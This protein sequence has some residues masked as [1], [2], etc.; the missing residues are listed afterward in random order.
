MGHGEIEA[1]PA[2]KNK[3]DEIQ[4][5]V[6]DVYVGVFF[7]GTNNNMLQ[8]MIGQKFRRDKIFKSRADALKKLG[9]KNANEVIAKPRS[10]WE[11]KHKDVF[12]KSDLDKLYGG[13]S[14]N[15]NDLEKEIVAENTDYS[16]SSVQANNE[17]NPINFGLG[18]QFKKKMNE[19][20][21]PKGN[22]K[23]S[24]NYLPDK[25]VW[26]AF[27]QSS[28]YTNPCILWSIYSTGEEQ[29]QQDSNHKIYHHRIYVEGSGSD[30]TV[31][32]AANVDGAVDD[33]IGLGFGV[34]YTG[35]S[36]KCRKMATQINNIYGMYHKPD[37]KEIRF[38]FD[39]FGFSRGATTARLFT[40]IVNPNNENNISNNDF[41]L[42]TGKAKTF[43]PLH[44][45]DSSSL[46]TKKEVRLLGIFDTVA[47]IG[48]LRDPFNTAVA[49]AIKIKD[50]NVEFTKYG[51]SQ[52]HDRNV[53]D[54]GL[55]ATTN[56]KDVLHICALD[57][58]RINFSLT[59][60]ESSVNSGNGTEIFLPGCHTDIGG[61]AGL[62]LDDF[63]VI[64]KETSNIG[65]IAG[66]LMQ[67]VTE[68][69]NLASDVKKTL[70]GAKNVGNGVKSIV[71]GYLKVNSGDLIGIQN[72]L[73]GVCTTYNGTRSTVAGVHGNLDTVVNILYETGQQTG[74]IDPALPPLPQHTDGSSDFTKKGV[75]RYAAD[76]TGSKRIEN[77]A[78][79]QEKLIEGGNAFVSGVG[80]TKGKIKDFFNSGKELIDSIFDDNPIM[81]TVDKVD[82]TLGSF[83]SLLH[84]INT[85]TDSVSTI[86]DAIKSAIHGHP[87]TDNTVSKYIRKLT[88]ISDGIITE[89][90]AIRND[91]TLTKDILDMLRWFKNELTKK[92]KVDGN[93][94]MKKQI[95]NVNDAIAGVA[96]TLGNCNTTIAGVEMMLHGLQE[97]HGVHGSVNGIHE[98]TSGIKATYLAAHDS[99][100]S[101]TQ[102][103]TGIWN[104]L[105]NIFQNTMN[106]LFTPK[107]GSGQ[108]SGQ[109]IKNNLTQA[110]QGLEGIDQAYSS[111][112][113][114]TK[115]ALEK[116]K[117]LKFDS[118]NGIENS[119]SSVSS[120][121]RFSESALD[122]L[123]SMVSSV[124]Q[125]T[126]NLMGLS[127]NT[128]TALTKDR[129]FK[130]DFLNPAKK[131]LLEYLT[132]E[133][134][135]SANVLNNIGSNL[136][137]MASGL[138]EVVNSYGSSSN[139]LSG[140]I[141]T[142]KGIS[143]CNL[144]SFNG[145]LS[146]FSSTSQAITM[147]LNSMK[148]FKSALEKAKKLTTNTIGLG[149]NL[150]S[151]T[152][153]G[154]QGI[155]NGLNN[156]SSIGNAIKDYL[157][158]DTGSS[159]SVIENMSSNI[160]NALSGITG[161]HS[162]Y[163]NT[164]SK[165]KT[166]F[167]K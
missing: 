139:N 31:T 163:D 135:S 18:D 63:K 159:N 22:P 45:E 94:A 84:E 69:K 34:G 99:I 150:L 106:G 71:N 112:E 82:Q 29:D 3:N 67:K 70:V 78:N 7:D 122:N 12:T 108:G 28:T 66:T 55:Y 75:L 13:A 160:K 97:F 118:M 43:L 155:K 79:Q 51:K 111:L 140:A 16:Y 93:M 117:G 56:A 20:A 165:H 46:L 25:A 164:L 107:K 5:L 68:A 42:F 10:F 125:T 35:V 14:V 132:P 83:T 95:D 138:T 17:D 152:V 65:E 148:D 136:Q 81:D 96:Q 115:L 134:G 74:A 143:N 130:E 39:V 40:Y 49:D 36:A 48:I 86:A 52:F 30:S 120:A 128:Y 64:N 154:Y 61:G 23:K 153:Q 62:G 4:K 149:S 162:S 156:L 141:E 133:T 90:T 161:V 9:Y 27:S 151:A 110:A 8:S 58:N 15:S 59:D 77:L 57:E 1:K 146:A 47:S 114:N 129:N 11:N 116:L 19:I 80:K 105:D 33:V 92:N 145:V 89:C 54:F 21:D 157:N 87:T 166:P 131:S 158:P 38:H 144:H 24:K 41:L 126:S 26:G 85:T 53:D 60:I 124:Q 121:I 167:N 113:Q 147:S 2:K 103:S 72:I 127:V 76:T 100:D 6:I 73:E 142:I 123:S 88:F 109:D 91:I 119:L 98:L 37:V 44:D 101:I 32:L 137:N 104:N 50:N 102:T